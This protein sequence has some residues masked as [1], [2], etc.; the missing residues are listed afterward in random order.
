MQIRSKS[1]FAT[2]LF[3][4]FLC[5]ISMQTTSC[6][7]L[8]SSE[9]PKA[10]SLNVRAYKFRYVN[11]DSSLKCAKAALAMSEDKSAS[12]AFALNNLAYIAYQ[13]MRYGTSIDYL[14]K[15][16]KKSRNQIELLCAD[17]MYMKVAQR[18]GQGLMFF[19]HRNTA[20]RRLERLAEEENILTE[21]QYARLTYAKSEMHIVSST[22]Y[23]Y[24]GQAEQAIT[25][26]NKT[27]LD[28]SLPTDTA[29]WLYYRYMLGSGGLLK[30]QEKDVVLQEFDHL[31]AAYTTAS[32]GGLVYFLA[33]SLQSMASL[34]DNPE[35]FAY[36][37]ANRPN[38]LAFL[39]NQ[40][41]QW[42]QL[43]DIED[44]ARL[45]LVMADR[46]LH[47]FR[48]YKD[49]FQ[50]ACAYRTVGEI[51]FRHGKYNYA[52]RQFTHA[53]ELVESQK[54]RSKWQVPFWTFSIREYL[55]L[56]Y[57]ALDDKHNSDLHRNA[58]LKFLEQYTQNYELE[59]RKQQLEME[60][61]HT[62]VS[63]LILVG[64]ILLSVI[65]LWLLIRRIQHQSRH[66]T[67][68]ILSIRQSSEWKRFAESAELADT[69]LSDYRQEL[70]EIILLHQ[71]HIREY[72]HGNVERRAKVSLVYAIIPYLDRIIAE[73]NKMQRDGAADENRL[74]YI[75]ELSG[76]IMN[77][78]DVLT[79]WIQMR[80]GQF[81]LHIT[82]FPLQEV[83]DIISGS[84][85][86]FAKKGI[87]LNVCPTSCRVK[88]DMALT[89]F[90]IN[91]LCDNAR[92]FTPTGGHVNISAQPNEDYVEVSVSDSGIGLSEHDVEVL[93]QSKIYDPSQLGGQNE[94]KGFGFGIMNCK[95]IISKYKKTSK[96]FSVCDFG[97]ESTSGKGSRFW[98]RLPG[99][100]TVLLFFSLSA[101][102]QT[103]NL[104]QMAS[105]SI[106]RA[107]KAGNY[108]EAYAYGDAFLRDMPHPVDTPSVIYILNE[109]AV[110]SLSLKQWD[111]YYSCNKECVRL[112]HLFTADSSLPAY[113]RQM[114]QMKSNNVF[115]Y[116]LLV[117]LSIVALV[118][119]YL[120]SLRGIM[121]RDS[122]AHVFYNWLVERIEGFAVMMNNYAAQRQKQDWKPVLS[123]K[124]E[125]LSNVPE[126]M[127]HLNTD[128]M[129]II[130]E[131]FC[132]TDKMIDK[133][134]S[135]TATGRK[136]RYEEDRLYVM[137][138]VLDNCLSTI[139]HETMYYPART[140]QLVDYMRQ[141]GSAQDE[142]A[143]L[144]ELTELVNF[145]RNIYVLL[146]QQAVRQTEQNNFYREQIF[147]SEL[148]K[149]L[150]Q[151]RVN[152]DRML[153]TL[154]L[155]TLRDAE[156]VVPRLSAVCR[157]PFVYVKFEYPQVQR[158]AYDLENLFQP[159][160]R[161]IPFLVAKQIIREHDSYCNH[162]GLRLYAEATADGYCIV[163]T[164]LESK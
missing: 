103:G 156:P 128:C 118:L 59:E 75:S 152:G 24:Y 137:N 130:E 89:M 104:Y 26:I 65:L 45:S 1:I 124:P 100:M 84:R 83:F 2:V 30:G 73:A 8:V 47:L 140:Q 42:H 114:E 136:L 48:N 76:E 51:Y 66:L 37:S 105:D 14:D 92:K 87:T 120:L 90:M 102:S 116:A 157:P 160:S 11:I 49:L 39:Q 82:T 63:L 129:R 163:F 72:R 41:K 141:P 135:L 99:I 29:Q 71:K 19:K 7:A 57:S 134:D 122:Y 111:K 69:E 86:I 20:L 31:F 5:A 98:F 97:V 113:C 154:L 32:T 143:Y 117:L 23:F 149:S 161:H 148:D 78:N 9:N 81:K 109:M 147:L 36:I 28:P 74:R 151:I 21:M 93:N 60:L 121:R 15:I 123:E 70:E 50:L 108:N 88:A 38:S 133:S 132:K 110:S 150:P 95:G 142:K 96:K 106:S 53:L 159:L 94:N 158:T 25:E 10:D 80:Q 54:Q 145:Y 79:D 85:T 6:S 144:N 126:N 68:S 125:W 64:L 52:L 3:C 61:H 162:A 16:Y 17:V 40:H 27:Y 127:M 112:H 139:K 13:Q 46:A 107:N 4:V 153:L 35:T 119:F 58:Y 91:T 115:V 43:P 22:Y 155:Q 55:S 34:L 33:N 18:T 131:R 44:Y 146:Y 101:F 67:D 12:Q 62:R 77:V 164:L 56:T 138:Q